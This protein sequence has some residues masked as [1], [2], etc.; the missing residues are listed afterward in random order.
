M[1]LELDKVHHYVKQPGTN[2][3]R[4]VNTNPYVRFCAEGHP[5]VFLQGGRFFYENGVEI[6]EIERWLAKEIET[7]NAK[8]LKECG[9]D[10]DLGFEQGVDEEPLEELGDELPPVKAA[11]RAVPSRDTSG[12]K[13]A[14]KTAHKPVARP[15]VKR[16]APDGPPPKRVAPRR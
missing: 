8:V 16:A 13:V 15:T 7:A 2:D 14:A 4:L 11:S 3:V 5:V 6:D 9:Y 12:K 1:P 10:E